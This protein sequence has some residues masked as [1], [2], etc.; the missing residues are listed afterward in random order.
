LYW[1]TN[2][3]ESRQYLD[4]K[5]AEDCRVMNKMLP[6][7]LKK[8]LLSN[9]SGESGRNAMKSIILLLCEMTCC[10]RAIKMDGRPSFPLVYT[11]TGTYVGALFHGECHTCKT[12]FYPSYKDVGSNKAK[13]YNDPTDNSC[14]YFQVTSKTVFDKQLLKYFTNN[15][16]V[17]GTTFQSRAKVYNL[18][19]GDYHSL[20]EEIARKNEGGW[21]LNE[22]RVNDAWFKWIIVNYHQRKNS[23]QEVEIYLKYNETSR[24]MNTETLC[25]CKHQRDRILR[26]FV[27]RNY[28]YIFDFF[29]L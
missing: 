6:K 24:H 3:A 8:Q 17:S 21:W 27:N 9:F 22:E 1:K 11:M 29:L 14:R 13:M 12:K 19:F 5:T 2:K 18:N 25:D 15:I 26:N 4:L 16:C 28:I 10:K 20:L 23:L 7:A